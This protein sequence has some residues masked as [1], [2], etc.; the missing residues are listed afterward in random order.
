MKRENKQRIA[1]RWALV[2]TSGTLALSGLFASA[3]TAQAA[4]AWN[5]TGTQADVVG[6][7]A[8]GDYWIDTRSYTSYATVTITDSKADHASARVYFHWRWTWGGTSGD[9]GPLTASGYQTEKTE[10]YHMDRDSLDTW[11]PFEVK[12]CRVDNGREV[13]CGDWDVPKPYN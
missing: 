7:W 9:Y 6:A 11:Q 5:A 4:T 10:T 8:H 1:R 2:A 13:E 12:E 3:G